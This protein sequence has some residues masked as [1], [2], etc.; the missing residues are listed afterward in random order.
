MTYTSLCF[1]FWTGLYK[2]YYLY[3][4]IWGKTN[5]YSK[6]GLNDAIINSGYLIKYNFEKWEFLEIN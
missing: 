5:T 4:Y 3:K 2:I 1:K 6:Y